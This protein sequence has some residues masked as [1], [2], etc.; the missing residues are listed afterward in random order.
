MHF[1]PFAAAAYADQQ[2]NQRR[3]PQLHPHQLH[4]Q[5]QQQQQYFSVL[6]PTN[7]SRPSQVPPPLQ[8]PAETA[9]AVAAAAFVDDNAQGRVAAAPNWIQLAAF[10]SAVPVAGS[11]SAVNATFV[12]PSNFVVHLRPTADGLSTMGHYHRPPMANNVPP[13]IPPPPPQ[14]TAHVPIPAIPGHNPQTHMQQHQSFK[15]QQPMAPGICIATRAPHAEFVPIAA[16]PQCQAVHALPCHQ[17]NALLAPPLAA[18]AGAVQQPMPPLPPPHS[19]GMLLPVPIVPTTSTPVAAMPPLRPQQIGGAAG[20]VSGGDGDKSPN[21]NNNNNKI[22]GNNGDCWST[23]V[24]GWEQAAIIK[25]KIGLLINGR[26]RILQSIASGSYGEIFAAEDLQQRRHRVAVK[27]DGACRD[28]HLRYEYQVY[29]S[30]LYEDGNGKVD[31]FPQVYWYGHEYGHNILVMELL[32]AP[33]ASLFAFCDRKFAKQTIVSLGEQMIHRIRHLHQR[34]FI[35]RDIKPENFLMGLHGKESTLYLIDFGLA[36]RYRYRENRALTHIPFRRGRSFIGTAKYASLNSHKNIELSR[37]D[38][39]ESL[40]YVLIELI[41]GHLPWKNISKRNATT[42]HQTSLRIRTLKEQTNWEEFCP[43]MAK[44]IKYCREIPFNEEPDYDRLLDLLQM[45]SVFSPEF[46]NNAKLVSSVTVPLIVA[47]PTTRTRA[48][49]KMPSSVSPSLA[50][51]NG[52]PMCCQMPATAEKMTQVDFESTKID[53]NGVEEQDDQ[54]KMDTISEEIIKKPISL[55]HVVESTIQH[56]SSLKLASAAS[57]TAATTTTTTNCAGVSSDA[58]EMGAA[59]TTTTSCSENEMLALDSAGGGDGDDRLADSSRAAESSATGEI[60]SIGPAVSD[61]DDELTADSHPALLQQDQPPPVCRKCRRLRDQQNQHKR[62]QL[63]Q[64]LQPQQQQRI[65]VVSPKRMEKKQ[66]EIE[67]QQQQHQQQK[68]HQLLLLQSQ[69]QQQQQQQQQH[70][71][72]EQQ[73]KMCWQQARDS[74]PERRFQYEN[75]FSWTMDKQ[76]H[77]QQQQQPVETVQLLQQHQQLQQQQQQQQEKFVM[78][79]Y[80]LR[81]SAALPIGVPQM[82]QQY[83]HHHQQQ[84]Q[85]QQ[86]VAPSQFVLQHQRQAY[87]TNG[88]ISPAHPIGMAMPSNNVQQ[89]PAT[90]R[91]VAHSH[92]MLLPAPAA[93]HTVPS[94][95]AAIQCQQIAKFGTNL[96]CTLHQ[97]QQAS[98]LPPQLSVPT[99]AAAQPQQQQNKKRFMHIAFVLPPPAVDAKMSLALTKTTATTTAQLQQKQNCREQ[100]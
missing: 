23:A 31:G 69:Q 60:C 82:Q 46:N 10:P 83:L 100:N 20:G 36:R 63:H 98:S 43:S 74:N 75:R 42:R 19:T 84:Q 91:T 40:A 47:A 68:L 58:D 53:E 94:A 34:G 32:G 8:Q 55:T 70:Q 87:C 28:N 90:G 48:A 12:E 15:L 76:H 65:V 2:Q 38:D 22:G 96:N 29:K 6:P 85:Q 27:F 39:V 81:A 3:H 67:Q 86:F 21:N 92:Y 14:N 5:Q 1:H 88:H 16:A 30:A 89:L 41:N 37:R 54:Q 59:T 51:F 45:I 79:C 24:T 99:I 9:A 80:N 57:T 61:G 77:Q 66:H 78:P 97:Q 72:P 4:Q 18:A 44:F 35:H 95:A 71:Q 52:P 49:E 26:F 33:V 11:H 25:N 56:L 62:S 7:S 93:H 17:N 13:G 64:P 73:R 50:Q